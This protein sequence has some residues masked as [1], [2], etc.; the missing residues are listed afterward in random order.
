MP[1]IIFSFY[2]SEMWSSLF[3]KTPAYDQQPVVVERKPL[4]TIYWKKVHVLRPSASLE[5]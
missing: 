5:V 1:P 2:L 3:S 4:F